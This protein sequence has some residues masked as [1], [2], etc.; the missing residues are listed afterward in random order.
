MKERL[1]EG[2]ITSYSWLS[3][4]IMWTDILTKEMRLLSG[5]EKVIKNGSARD[6]GKPSEGVWYRDTDDKYPK[7]EDYD[8]SRASIFFYLRLSLVKLA[9]N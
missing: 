8:L 3:T 1:V 5:L 2:D 6:Y 9:F 7:Q 4:D